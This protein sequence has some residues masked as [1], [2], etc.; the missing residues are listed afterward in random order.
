MADAAAGIVFE[1]VVLGM[2]VRAGGWRIIWRN[3]VSTGWSRPGRQWGH[4]RRVGPLRLRV[5]MTSSP[6]WEQRAVGVL[7]RG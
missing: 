6:Q 7:D 2:T 5:L 3:S 1:L 4:A